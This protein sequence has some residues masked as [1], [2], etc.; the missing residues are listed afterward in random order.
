MATLYGKRWGSAA[1]IVAA[2]VLCQ[3]SIAEYSGFEVKADLPQLPN[4]VYAA[5]D[6]ELR[7][8]TSVR[9][10]N[11]PGLKMSESRWG[12]LYWNRSARDSVTTLDL[13]GARKLARAFLDRYFPGIRDKRQFIGHGL[14]MTEDGEGKSTITGY[15]I[16]YVRRYR[17]L[18]VLNDKIRVTIKGDE[19]V[20]VDLAVYSVEEVG[21]RKKLLS[22]AQCLA[23]VAEQLKMEIGEDR[24]I[25]VGTVQFGYEGG[26]VQS[27]EERG[28]NW[29]KPF[30]AV[31]VYKFTAGPAGWP[32]ASRIFVFDART[33]E[34]IYPKKATGEREVI[35][36]GPEVGFTKAGS[37]EVFLI[38]PR[39]IKIKKAVLEMESI[40]IE[41]DWITYTVTEVFGESGTRL[42]DYGIVSVWSLL[43][44]TTLK[45]GVLN[46]ETA[47]EYEVEVVVFQKFPRTS[48]GGA[49]IGIDG[50][51]QVLGRKGP[52]EARIWERWGMVELSAG[53]HIVEVRTAAPS[54]RSYEI[55][56]FRLRRVD[57]PDANLSSVK[58]LTI[59]IGGSGQSKP[60]YYSA[61]PPIRRLVTKNLSN[62]LRSGFHGCFSHGIEGANIC[63]INISF[64]SAGILRI[65]SLKIS[66]LTG[67]EKLAEEKAKQFVLIYPNGESSRQLYLEEIR[68]FVSYVESIIF[69]PRG[70]RRSLLKSLALC[71]LAKRTA[72]SCQE[73]GAG[74]VRSKLQNL[75]IQL[76]QK[77]AK[78]LA[79]SFY[80]TS[81]R[82]PYK[83]VRLVTELGPQELWWNTAWLDGKRIRTNCRYLDPWGNPYIVKYLEQ[84]KRIYVRSYGA[85]GKDNAGKGDDIEAVGYVNLIR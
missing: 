5:A 28:K 11:I 63:S 85:D 29:S 77:E 26:F 51:L 74:Q 7:A 42:F 45:T 80:S 82:K 50:Q 23:K 81:G 54:G 8:E 16:S 67:D 65:R 56:P 68:V 35:I 48:Y 39:D 13:D 21:Q 25:A 36:P 33:A 4:G 37:Y 78:R 41:S 18:P 46:I 70:L 1:C 73:Q 76:V 6:I 3:I 66:F 17:S 60:S 15:T 84:P 30:R 20:G 62:D 47:G 27:W 64:I 44:G 40:P 9:D 83:D 53:E 24:R 71:E 72:A 2:A 55:G 22:A 32:G 31:P 61:V 79:N 14:Y 12:V 43:R 58:D 34:L 75:Y 49:E 59:G 52:D 19:V 69:S 57:G 10:A 38:G